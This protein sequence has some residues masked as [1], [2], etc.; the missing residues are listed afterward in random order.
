VLPRTCAATRPQSARFEPVDSLERLY[1]TGSSRTP[2]DLACR[3]R[4]IWRYW[5]VPSLSGLLPLSPAPP[6]S[7]CPQLHIACCDRRSVRVSHPDTVQWRLMA[8]V[9]SN[10][11][12]VPTVWSARFLGSP[13]EPDVR[14]STHPALHEFVSVVATR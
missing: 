6:G 14:V 10:R 12:A 13:S 11:G 4:A 2:S 7:S 9:G 8:H 1:D 5:P 3:T